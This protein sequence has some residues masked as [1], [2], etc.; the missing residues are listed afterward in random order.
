MSTVS[1]SHS[2][3]L[4]HDD[5]LQLAD[6]LG[7]ELAEKYSLNTEW[8]E[9]TLNFEGAGVHGYID[10]TPNSIDIVAKLGFMWLPMRGMIQS[11][12]RRI[13]DEHFE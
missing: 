10:V 1:I 7:S 12:M 11:E 9:D 6:E 3:T 4:S 5:A 8:D 13:L 2:H